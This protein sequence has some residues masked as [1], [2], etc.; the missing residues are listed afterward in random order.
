MRMAAL[1]HFKLCRAI[2]V[3]FRNQLRKDGTCKEGVVGMLD[4][5]LER[6]E[7]PATVSCFNLISSSGQVLKVQIENDKVFRDDLTGQFLDSTSV[8]TS[9]KKDLE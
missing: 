9:R 8:A 7:V 1:Y 4:A 3:G 2:L 6:E 5:G